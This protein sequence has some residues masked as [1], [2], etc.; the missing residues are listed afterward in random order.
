MDFRGTTTPLVYAISNN[1]DD[2]I[3]G[4]PF[5]TDGG[6]FFVSILG[7]F[8]LILQTRMANSALQDINA[9]LDD[10]VNS[11]PSVIIGFGD[12]LVNTFCKTAR[13]ASEISGRVFIVK[14]KDF[15]TYY[16]PSIDLSVILKNIADT[17]YV[18]EYIKQLSKIVDITNGTYVDVLKEKEILSAHSF[19]EFKNIYEE[20]YLQDNEIAYDI[21]TNAR[22]I[23]TADSRIIG[24]SIGN[25]TSGVYV[26]VDSLEWHMSEDEENK[27]WDYTINKIFEKKD[28]LIIHN[29]MYERPYTLCCKNYPI[30]FEK[31]HDTLVMARMLRNPKEPAGLKYQAQTNLNYPDW[32]TD[33]NI[34]INTFM[35]FVNKV[36]LGAKKYADV[37]LALNNG[38]SLFDLSTNLD[39]PFT[40][41]TFKKDVQSTIDYYVNQFKRLL[42]DYYAQDEIDFIGKLISEKLVY[43]INNGGVQDSVIPYNWIPDRMLSKY[44]ALDSIATY[45]LKDYFFNRMTNESTSTVNLFKGYNLWLQHMYVAYIMER[46]GLYWNETIASKDYAFLNEQATTCLKS[47]LLSPLFKPYI[48]TTCNEKY[49]STIINDYFPEIATSQGLNLNKMSSEKWKSLNIPDNYYSQYV[50]ILEMLFYDDVE[51]ETSWENLKDYYNPISS[52]ESTDVALKILMVPEIQY[53]AKLVKLHTLSISPAFTQEKDTLNNYDKQILKIADYCCDANKLKEI[54]G[55]T[56]AQNRRSLFLGF[57]DRLHD[58]KLSANKSIKKILDE[59]L[60]LT[61]DTLDDNGIIDVYDNLIVT[62]IDQDDKT[63]WTDVFEWMINFRLFKK[64]AKI[65][66]SYIEGSV[67]HKSIYIVNRDDF[68]NPNHL[69]KRKR[70]YTLSVEPDET[71]L[72]NAKWSPNTADTGRW[73]SAQHTIPAGS[74]VKKY[75]TSRFKGGT[76]LMPDY[77]TM[78]VRALAAISRDE[79]MLNVFKAGK[80]FHTETAKS[81]FRKED[82]TPAERKFSKG[83]TFSLLYGSS[84]T[85]FAKAYCD[86]DETYAQ[87]IFDGFFK[88]YPKVQQWV[89][90][91]HLEVQKDQRVSLELSNRFIQIPIPKDVSKGELGKILRQSQNFPIQAQSA[92]LTGGVVF[93]LQ[94]YLEQN[95]YLSSIVMYIHDSIEVDTHPYELIDVISTFKNILINSPMERFG[96]PAKADVTL[97]YS[98]GHEI[99]ME[100]I[101]IIN[102][103][104]CII[105]MSGYKD[106]IEDTINNWKTVYSVVSTEESSFKS[107][108]ISVGDLFIPKKAYTPTIG[109]L[110]SKGTCKVRIEY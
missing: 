52:S 30:S 35:D 68:K 75:Y 37:V 110:R 83:A 58:K 63:T 102:S 25:K 23:L 27:I 76:M 11:K 90:E 82:I 1:A 108:L 19:E 54:Y 43:C 40:L 3:K 6:N 2:K 96:L 29:T 38:V 46:N 13:M 101:E 103:E 87:M 47:L 60:S 89:E 45:D 53:G 4:F 36:G 24:F 22:P 93:D 31:A 26:S 91:R 33:L 67:G 34:Y 9:I 28:K 78:E 51:K 86:G 16:I 62:G 50:K 56:W 66:T 8:N 14:I 17:A 72:M 77:S 7:S 39:N 21:E 57:C 106:E 49:K 61:V 70:P 41:Y 81:I 10:I 97:G 88:A 48:F 42:L 32:E 105:T 79:N 107:R 69:I 5:S 92:D 98:L 95:N 59:K 104:S 71:Y 64:S 74:Q 85:S 55:D 18:T 84:V 44:G 15:E 100:D 12:E 65:I 109:T 20:K 73:R 99:D 80:D 94:K